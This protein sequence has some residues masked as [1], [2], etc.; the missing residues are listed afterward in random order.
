MAPAG[1]GV[2]VGEPDVEADEGVSGGGVLVLLAQAVTAATQSTTAVI[3]RRAPIDPPCIVPFGWSYVNGRPRWCRFLALVSARLRVASAIQE[4]PHVEV[5]EILFD[6]QSLNH[7]LDDV[8]GSAW[9]LRT[10]QRVR[11]PLLLST[12]FIGVN[13]T[14]VATSLG[15]CLDLPGGDPDRLIATH[16]WMIHV[17]SVGP[18]LRE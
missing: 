15:R 6:Q 17:A 7:E 8:G 3:S 12:S 11:H 13:G 14:A 5:T 4:F 9:A 2:G 18:P 16:S 1:L 10:Q